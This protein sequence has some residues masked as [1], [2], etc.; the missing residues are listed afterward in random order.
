M[1]ML[2][3]VDKEN[4]RAGGDPEKLCISWIL[5]GRAFIIRSKEEMAKQLLPM[6]F[7]QSK[8]P[9]FT[10]KLYRWGFRQVSVV[11]QSSTN[12]RDM[13]FGHEFFQRDDKALMGRMRSVTAAGTR[14]AVQARTAKLVG[15]RTE[16][17]AIEP[18]SA[19][20]AQLAS[21]SP[22]S[23]PHY[24]CTGKQAAPKDLGDGASLSR[25]MAAPTLQDALQFTNQQRTLH[26][27]QYAVLQSTVNNT[28]PTSTNEVADGKLTSTGRDYSITHGGVVMATQAT[29]CTFSNFANFALPNAA[30]TIAAAQERMR[31]QYEGGS[32][33]TDPNAYMRA[34]VDLLLRYA[35]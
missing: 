30:A 11:Q 3:Y 4:K 25:H 34:A 7:R 29:D 22:P 31:N 15:Q 21:S 17:L 27:Q 5:D 35:S 13:I 6:F 16:T 10:R 20:I 32:E 2:V 12:R 33:S 1:L 18:K 19:L 24:H 23:C 14:R 9:S 26:V 8:F 28:C